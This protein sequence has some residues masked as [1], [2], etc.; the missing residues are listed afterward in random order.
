M[1]QNG[2]IPD[3]HVS[4]QFEE[5]LSYMNYLEYQT[6]TQFLENSNSV[7]L[8]YKFEPSRD[9]TNIIFITATYAHV[10]EITFFQDFELFQNQ[11]VTQALNGTTESCVARYIEHEWG[12][13]Y[14]C[15]SNLLVE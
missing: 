4:S 12:T 11:A 7:T 13:G 14:E 5:A 10:R 3:Y 9:L 1:R 15:N 8:N 2:F 6:C